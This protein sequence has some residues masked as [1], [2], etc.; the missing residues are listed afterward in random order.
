[1]IPYRYNDPKI[2]GN[3][4]L[5][6]LAAVNNAWEM[7]NYAKSAPGTVDVSYVSGMNINSAQTGI[8]RS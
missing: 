7:M 2:Q 6:S 1:M 4:G 5:S 3:P 8:V